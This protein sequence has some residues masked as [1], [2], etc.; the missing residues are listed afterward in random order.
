M[1]PILQEKSEWDKKRV[2]LC[3]FYT[4]PKCGGNM[5]GDG[6]TIARHCENV[7][8]PMDRE[9]DAPLLFCSGEDLA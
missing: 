2:N 6:Y 3:N 1:I 8:L 5:V 9:P 7:D 4:C